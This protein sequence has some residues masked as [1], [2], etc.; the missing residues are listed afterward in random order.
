MKNS[1]FQ[2]SELLN[3][4]MPRLTNEGTSELAIFR[5]LAPT[6]LFNTIALRKPVIIFSAA[7]L[8]LDHVTLALTRPLHN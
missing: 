3:D 8:G 7:L 6:L 2:S 1:V 4:G 5:E